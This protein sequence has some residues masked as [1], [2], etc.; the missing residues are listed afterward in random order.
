MRRTADAVLPRISG[1]G[2]LPGRFFADWEPAGF[3]S[4][5]T[6]SAQ[7]AIVFYGLF[8]QTGVAKYREHANKLVNYLKALQLLQSED[9]SVVGAIAGSFP[10]FGGYMRAGYPNWATKYFLDAVLLQLATQQR[11]LK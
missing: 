8:E 11:D 4:C 5:L 7:V 10:L 9:A 6:G 3:S 1:N 2:Y